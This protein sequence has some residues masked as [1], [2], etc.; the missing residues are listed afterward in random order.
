MNSTLLSIRPARRLSCTFESTLDTGCLQI[1]YSPRRDHSRPLRVEIIASAHLVGT[2]GKPPLRGTET[3][4]ADILHA[5]HQKGFIAQMITAAVMGNADT[6]CIIRRDGSAIQGTC[7]IYMCK[8]F[9]FGGPLNRKRPQLIPK[10]HN[11]RI[12]LRAFIQSG[13]AA[14]YLPAAFIQPNNLIFCAEQKRLRKNRSQTG[15]S[16]PAPAQRSSA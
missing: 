14:G 12:E 10:I 13:L 16:M 8:D 4:G 2:G 7:G 6:I 3:H 5:L 1:D 11:R 9:R 15:Q